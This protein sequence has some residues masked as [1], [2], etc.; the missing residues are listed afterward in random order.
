MPNVMVHIISPRP[1]FTCPWRIGT[2]S[3]FQRNV[4]LLHRSKATIRQPQVRLAIRR[5]NP[6]FLLHPIKRATNEKPQQEKRKNSFAWPS[7]M[8]AK[9]PWLMATSK[10]NG[11]FFRCLRWPAS[12]ASSSNCERATNAKRSLR[13]A[14]YLTGMLTSVVFGVYP[15]VLPARNPLYSLTVA[16]AKAGDYG[17]KIGLVWWIIGIILEALEPVKGMPYNSGLAESFHRQTVEPAKPA[18]FPLAFSTRVR[19]RA[20][21]CALFA[22]HQQMDVAG[23]NSAR[24]THPK[25]EERTDPRKRLKLLPR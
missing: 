18:D 13:P 8:L 10:L 16:T 25:A 11:T 19:R 14:A 4:T 5:T 6:E 9:P 2:V 21:P 1:G 3:R 20:S 24:G 15:M 12:R 23:T 22:L 7:A 17:L